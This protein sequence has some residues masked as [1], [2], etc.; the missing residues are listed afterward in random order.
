MPSVS[1]VLSTAN[2]VLVFLL[3]GTVTYGQ[4]GAT[5]AISGGVVDA[6]GGSVA[7]GEV[8]I[9]DARTEVLVRKLS[10]DSD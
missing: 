4:G 7:G 2:L 6:S 9:I 10:K 8:Q 3:A 1:R 5:G